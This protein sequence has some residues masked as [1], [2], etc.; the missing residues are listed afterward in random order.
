MVL[1]CDDPFTD[2]RKKIQFREE[3]WFQ[4][5]MQKDESVDREKIWQNGFTSDDRPW[6][7]KGGGHSAA[8]IGV[9]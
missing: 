8:K 9:M 2:D 7:R 5:I 4:E 6:E 1:R 3:G